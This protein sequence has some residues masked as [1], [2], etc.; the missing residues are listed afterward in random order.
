[1]DFGFNSLSGN[2][3][4]LSKMTKLQQLDLSSNLLGGYIIVIGLGWEATNLQILDLSYNNFVGFIP[5]EI[6]E[7]P[8]L[9]ELY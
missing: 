2:L 6:F 1:M 9:S 4:D 8:N 7:N 3:I 5:S